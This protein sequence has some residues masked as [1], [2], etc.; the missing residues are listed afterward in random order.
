MEAWIAGLNDV[1]RTNDELS[2]MDALGKKFTIAATTI[3]A[4]I[5]SEKLMSSAQSDVAM[6]IKDAKLKRPAVFRKN[7]VAIY[8]GPRDSACDSDDVKSKKAVTRLRCERIKKLSPD[9]VV[10]WAASYSATSWAGGYMAK[11]IFDC[12]IND[13]EPDWAQN[14]PPVIQETLQKL[15]TD[16]ALK[17]SPEYSKLVNAIIDPSRRSQARLGEG[18]CTNDDQPRTY[19]QIATSSEPHVGTTETWSSHS[20]YKEPF[21]NGMTQ[22]QRALV[23]TPISYMPL[24]FYKYSGLLTI[25]LE[26]ICG[27]YLSNAIK[28]SCLWN[29]GAATHCFGVAVPSDPFQDCILV[30]SISQLAGSQLMQYITTAIY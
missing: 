2:E 7:I 28:T 9:G 23:F 29:G 24:G 14:W 20:L 17:N 15:W 16:E 12:L 26:N 19:G 27:P 22:E 30:M 18:R 6:L 3:Q 8:T 4:R 5:A 11:D 13:I 21:D 1:P 10:A 25:Q